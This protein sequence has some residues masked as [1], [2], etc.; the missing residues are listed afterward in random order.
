MIVFENVTKSFRVGERRKI[1]LDRAS[2]AVTAG[3]PLGILAP[4]GTGKTTVINM[5]AGIERPDEGVIRRSSRVSLPLGY[6]GGISNRHTGSENARRAAVLHHADPDIIESFT[7]W[8]AGIGQHM[9]MPTGTWSQGTRARFG[10]SLMLAF[11]FDFYL[12]DEGMP[13]TTDAAFNKRAM[14]VLQQRLACGTAVIVSHMPEVIEKFCG[15]ASV[16]RN[17][18]LTHY[19]DLASARRAYDYRDGAA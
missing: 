15:R 8:M 12:I 16:L 13:V 4:N 14:Q 3:R 5:M 7:D 9:A 1:I 18:V 6:M 11:E 2:F 17:G 10:F 19:P